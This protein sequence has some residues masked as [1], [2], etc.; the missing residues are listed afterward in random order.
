MQDYLHSRGVAHRDL[1]PENIL[2][3]GFGELNGRLRCAIN[4]SRSGSLLQTVQL[5]SIVCTYIT[6]TGILLYYSSD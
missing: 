6:T 5:Q 4:V 3:D 2:L 1:K